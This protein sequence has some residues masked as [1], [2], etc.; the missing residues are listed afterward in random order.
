MA[1]SVTATTRALSLSPLLVLLLSACSG[2][3]ASQAP[4]DAGAPDT[5]DA[6]ATPDTNLGTDEGD[7]DDDTEFDDTALDDVAVERDAATDPGSSSDVVPPLDGD[8]GD[9]DVTQVSDWDRTTA[10]EGDFEIQVAHGVDVE[11]HGDPPVR[12]PEMRV[13]VCEDHWPEGSAARTEI[14]T[15]VQ[16]F[17]D[18]RGAEVDLTIEYGP[19]LDADAMYPDDVD[20]T[21][22]TVRLDYV[23][24]SYPC[25]QRLDDRWDNGWSLNCCRYSEFGAWIEI[26][27]ACTFNVAINPYGRDHDEDPTANDYPKAPNIAHEFGHGFGQMHTNI[28]PTEDRV[29]ISTMQG[30]LVG[31]SAYDVAFLRVQ[32][33]VPEP[34]PFVDLV[35]SPVHRTRGDGTGWVRTYFGRS[36]TV[37]ASRQDLNPS[38]LFVADGVLMDCAMLS[39]AVIRASFFN[40]GTASTAWLEDTTRL[41][42]TLSLES[43]RGSVQL[44]TLNMG[45]VPAESQA[46]WMGEAVSDL[47]VEPG[48]WDLTFALN[49]A[50]RAGVASTS[51]VS[52]VEVY[53]SGDA[54]PE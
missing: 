14:E 28:W 52:P 45:E 9:A 6:I 37:N 23:Y 22:P 34:Q 44:R 31:L 53:G 29:L 1:I 36:H 17:N 18:V 25:H 33:G 15:A 19:H 43:E 42:A 35:P 10:V 32:N 13:V 46:Q 5:Q 21:V 2:R 39:P 7:T 48:Q 49:T 16:W 26:G 50:G 54:C 27:E 38:R 41:E 20:C 11:A 24:D 8:L 12:D 30:N 3:D 40:R 51:I 4:T 47:E